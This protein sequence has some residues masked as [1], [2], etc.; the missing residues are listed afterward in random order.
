M[1]GQQQPARP[2]Q[3]MAWPLH[4]PG[5]P[6]QWRMFTP[7]ESWAAR[8]IPAANDAAGNPAPEAA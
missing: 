3:S 8:Q 6:P 1:T 4:P 2:A 5:E 7:I